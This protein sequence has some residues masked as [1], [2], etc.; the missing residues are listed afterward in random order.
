MMFALL[1]PSMFYR[2][3]E[4]L[5]GVGV[6]VGKCSCDV[7]TFCWGRWSGSLRVFWDSFGSRSPFTRA[8][9]SIA[10]IGLFVDLPGSAF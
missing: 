3:L 8:S 1:V 10:N 9:R 2:C 7:F 5:D 4:N 6:V